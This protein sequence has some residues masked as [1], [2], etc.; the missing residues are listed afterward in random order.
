MSLSEGTE[1][2]VMKAISF[3]DADV[4]SGGNHSAYRSENQ[5]QMCVHLY[6]II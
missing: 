3:F 4:V 1:S 5:D 6:I 2:C